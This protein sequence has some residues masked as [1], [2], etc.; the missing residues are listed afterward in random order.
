MLVMHDDHSRGVHAHAVPHKGTDHPGSDLAVRSVCADIDSLGYK[1]VIF[2][3]DGETAL[4]SF[5]DAVGMAKWS[6]N[7]LLP[8]RLRAMGELSAESRRSRASPAR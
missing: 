1:R 8:A 2:K 7:D 3:D 5:L 4:V 6:L